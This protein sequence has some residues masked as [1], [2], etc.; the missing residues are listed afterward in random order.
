MATLARPLE[1]ASRSEEAVAEIMECAGAAEVTPVCRTVLAKDSYR[2]GEQ[3]EVFYRTLEHGNSGY[4]PVLSRAD[5]LRAPRVGQTDGWVSASV[6]RD[7]QGWAD[8]MVVCKHTHKFW[9]DQRGLALDMSDASNS[10]QRFPV[11][12]VRRCAK[13]G[14]GG[15]FGTGGAPQQVSLSLLLV[16]W[17]GEDA[18]DA[19]D[20]TEHAGSWG[21][22][23]AVVSNHYA[24]KL[25][26]AVYAVLGTDHEVVTAFVETAEDVARLCE[27]RVVATLSR[28]RHQGAIYLLWPTQFDSGTAGRPGMIPSH[29]LLALMAR[30]EQV[31]VPSRFPHAA[32]VYRALA[33]KEWTTTLSGAA[34]MRVPPTTRVRHA[35]SDDSDT[36]GILSS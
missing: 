15:R 19:C 32:H 6:E 27:R 33:S 18:P 28:G 14:S 1:D 29:A 26:N 30:M 36:N 10:V 21:A 17:G 9:C 24:A 7:F 11:E 12:R 16:R 23:G 4:F 31:G 25:L 8:E 20:S 2:A 5:G 13:A 3:V 35:A 34:A 22:S